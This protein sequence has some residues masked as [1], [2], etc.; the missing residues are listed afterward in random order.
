MTRV[1]DFNPINY[2]ISKR[3]SSLLNASL[4]P[5]A[6]E[7]QTK[8]LKERELKV[9]EYLTELRQKSSTEIQELVNL[10]RKKEADLAQSRLVREEAARWFNGPNCNADFGHWS[11]AAYWTLEE[12]IALSFGKE[13]V[14]VNWE[15]IK[16][17]LAV[18]PFVMRYNRRR[19]LAQRASA[20]NLLSTNNLPSFFLGWAKRN[21]MEPPSRLCELVEQNGQI[22]ADWPELLNR[23][24]Q[25]TKE[26][27]EQG[28]RHRDEALQLG[29][30]LNAETRE[31]LGAD[32]NKLIE[33]IAALETENVS[34]KSSQ[35]SVSSQDSQ[36]INAKSKLS[37]LKLVLGMAIDGY[38]FN[39]KSPRSPLP[40][41]LSGGLAALEIT[42]DESTVRAWLHEAMAE[43]TYKLKE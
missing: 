29:E 3:F 10:E 18:S 11:R 31:A 5:L 36:P 4:S 24:Q 17:S 39:P 19:D 23:A 41:E 9:E 21:E 12:G 22:I 15:S 2:L 14:H 16:S 37:L 25:R 34:L 27:F 20:M 40:R 28:A 7:N 33:R 35:I 13:P 38:G 8:L 26:A 30:K 6:G 43:V 32:V 1:S 42:L